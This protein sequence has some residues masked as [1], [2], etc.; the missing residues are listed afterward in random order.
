MFVFGVGG[1]I[2]ADQILW[3]YFIERP[4]FYQYRLDKSP[5]YMTEK[6]EVTIQENTAISDAVDKAGKAVIGVKV[7]T[8]NGV[9]LEGSG[10]IL[11]S[12]GL[13]VT[14]AD[15]LPKG[16]EFYFFIDGEWPAFQVLKT[17]VKRNLALVKVEKANLT[18]AGF[19]DFEKTRLGQSIFLLGR[20]FVSADQEK[21]FG[22]PSLII[23]E[24][25]VRSLNQ[26][27]IQTNLS[28]K[29]NMQGSPVFTVAGEVLGLISVNQ[30]G[31]VSVIP[32][33]QIRAFTGL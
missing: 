25:I 27:L 28:G 19:A 5:I 4:L 17:D 7:K 3:P 23:D 9:I 11:T 6:K 31:Q 18:T 1:G 24:G 12:D 16:A 14:T 22:S 8:K 29:G 32:V 21:F 10:L 33:P 30:A 20:D 15:L 13:V 26:N 2:F